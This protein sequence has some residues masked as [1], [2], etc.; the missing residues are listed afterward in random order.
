M[1]SVNPSIEWYQISKKECLKFSF[2]EKLTEK[3][4]DVAIAEW[5]EFFKSREE[6]KVNLVWD[7][8]KMKGYES[9]ARINWTNALK[10]LK[11]QIASIWLISD[12]TFIR[13]GASVMAMFSNLNIIPINS[14]EDIV[15]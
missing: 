13:L 7:C 1:K 10:E 12:S 3:E 9:G 4:A 8:R 5:K 11:S 15:L 6:K 14:E 2:G